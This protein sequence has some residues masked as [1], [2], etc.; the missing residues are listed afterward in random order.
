MPGEQASEEERQG[1]TEKTGG[2]VDIDFGCKESPSHDTSEDEREDELLLQRV[3]YMAGAEESSD[4]IV[5]RL[6]QH[7]S[8]SRGQ[9]PTRQF[10]PSIAS[11]EEPPPTIP[12]SVKILFVF[13]AFTMWS[14]AIIDFIVYYLIQDHGW[15]SEM[16]GTIT[17][18]QK[19]VPVVMNP[20]WVAMSE[21]I[22]IKAVCICALLCAADGITLLCFTH[23]KLLFSWG[24]YLA[25]FQAIRPLR[26][27]YVLMATH[28]DIRTKCTAY[29]NFSTD[30]MRP[31]GA[32]MAKFWDH[33]MPLKQYTLADRHRV[34]TFSS[35]VICLVNVVIM[36]L[37]FRNEAGTGGFKKPTDKA[38]KPKKIQWTRDVE[39]VDNGKTYMINGDRHANLLTSLTGLYFFLHSMACAV[40]FVANM[41]VLVNVFNLHEDTV[42]NIK[43]VQELVAIPAPLLIV[44]CRDRSDRFLLCVGFVINTVGMLVFSCPLVNSQL[45]PLFGMVMVR[46][47]QPFFYTPA[48]SGFSKMMG[49]RSSGYAL[50]IL[51]SLSALGTSFGSWLGAEFAL[52]YYGTWSF[53]LISYFP[54]LVAMAIVFWPGYF[55]RMS[56]DDPVTLALLKQW[57]RDEEVSRLSLP[58]DGSKL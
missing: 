9:T 32:V 43:L 38:G 7:S 19:F 34:T 58:A 49:V 44:W 39:V 46:A 45:Q 35:L 4:A 57:K 20:F 42:Q 24:A 6:S 27:S 12:R 18:I 3:Q 55:N 17:A 5:R 31:L 15:D 25:A 50:A 53:F 26:T 48:C 29:L 51:T 16:Y 47:A 56:D 37:F 23:W 30:G 14:E 11:V 22:G 1:L 28:K 52:T 54:S 41:P 21:I 40:Y 33:L 10:R 36:L 8:Y 13:S 2:S